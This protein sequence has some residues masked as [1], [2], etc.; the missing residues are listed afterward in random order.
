VTTADYGGE[1]LVRERS[2]STFSYFNHRRTFRFKTLSQ[3]RP[4]SSCG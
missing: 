4:Y 1:S 2:A 3:I